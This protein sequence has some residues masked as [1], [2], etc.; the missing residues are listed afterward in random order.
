[1]AVIAQARHCTSP[2]PRCT[3]TALHVPYPPQRTRPFVEWGEGGGQ[4]VFTVSLPKHGTARSLS[5]PFSHLMS[6]KNQCCPSMALH[7]PYPPRRTRPSWNEGGRQ[8]V[9]TVAR[10]PRTA[11]QVAYP[12][13]PRKTHHTCN[14][15]GGDR[16]CSTAVHVAYPPLPHVAYPPPTPRRLSPPTPPPPNMSWK[17]QN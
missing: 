13:P 6:G 3:S 17:N 15:G 12:P 8:G 16:K 14:G 2:I 5:P 4:G 7:V 11:Q 1:V 10:R 9:F